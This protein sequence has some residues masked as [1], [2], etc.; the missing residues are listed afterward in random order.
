MIAAVSA[1]RAGTL[2]AGPNTEDT[3]TLVEAASIKA[4]L[5]GAHRALAE[6]AGTAYPDSPARSLEE[7]ASADGVRDWILRET[8][9]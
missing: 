3:P 5:V 9:S 7:F 6:M 2:Y 1:D 8:T 4:G